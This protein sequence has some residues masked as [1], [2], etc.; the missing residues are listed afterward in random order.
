MYCIYCI[1][2]M[3]Y[4]EN[5]EK[6]SISY[7]LDKFSKLLSKKA[8]WFQGTPYPYTL[9]YLGNICFHTEKAFS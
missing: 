8:L 5:I 4:I 7:S 1:H 3:I 6:N 9:C 2:L